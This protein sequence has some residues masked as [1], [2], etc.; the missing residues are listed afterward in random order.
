MHYL[1][2]VLKV[3]IYFRE[4]FGVASTRLTLYMI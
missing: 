4:I 3:S 1:Q 2:N